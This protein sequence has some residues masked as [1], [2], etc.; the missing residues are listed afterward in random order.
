MLFSAVP[1]ALPSGSGTRPASRCCCC[2]A[3]SGW[4]WQCFCNLLLLPLHLELSWSLRACRCTGRLAVWCGFGCP[5]RLGLA[6]SR[7]GSPFAWLAPASPVYAAA[8]VY[9]LLPA[10]RQ[11]LQVAAVRR[12]QCIICQAVSLASSSGCGGHTLRFRN[13]RWRTGR[14]R[15]LLLLGAAPSWLLRCDPPPAAA[16]FR[17]DPSPLRLLLLLLPSSAVS[18]RP[19][20][21]ERTDDIPWP[22]G[23]AAQGRLAS[24]AQRSERRSPVLVQAPWAHVWRSAA[25]VAAAAAALRAAAIEARDE[26]AR[27]FSTSDCVTRA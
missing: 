4:R 18:V 13:Q 11:R 23:C 10:Q 24:L 20:W 1:P 5:F 7:C 8:C 14:R 27:H 12:V 21:P 9:L 25:A 6:F 15:P 3:C 19:T 2:S 16:A 26:T 22:A 17:P